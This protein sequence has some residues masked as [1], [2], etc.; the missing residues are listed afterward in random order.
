MSSSASAGPNRRRA[1]VPGVLP[2]TPPE[3]PPPPEDGVR[4]SAD[5]AGPNRRQAVVPAASPGTPPPLEVRDGDYASNDNERGNV[6]YGD[7]GY[8][9]GDDTDY[10]NNNNNNDNH[11]N[12][13]NRYKI[14][15][16]GNSGG[17]FNAAEWAV[18]LLRLGKFA[19]RGSGRLELDFAFGRDKISDGRDDDDDEDDNNYDFY[20]NGDDYGYE[21][22]GNYKEGPYDYGDYFGYDDDAAEDYEHNDD[23]YYY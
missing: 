9:G 7:N 1:E 22:F 6:R 23:D 19:I 3:S 13:K 5:S 21:D 2:A 4:S 20:R 11:N 15:R 14:K 8:G 16:V 12:N 10:D 17:D 18:A